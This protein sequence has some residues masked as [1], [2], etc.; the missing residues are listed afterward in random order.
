MSL[1]RI[2]WCSFIVGSSRLY[3]VFKGGYKMLPLSA[4][5][6]AQA[7]SQELVLVFFYSPTC[8]IS[9]NMHSVVHA[10]EDRLKDK[11]LFCK[12]DTQTFPSLAAQCDV[13]RTP[14]YLI[15]KEGRI[16]ASLWG[17]QSLDDLLKVLLAVK[18]NAR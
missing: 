12:V 18:R 15:Y 7:I 13:R 11:V 2:T 14:E 17:T 10:L 6:Y 8:R 16:C 4:D 9:N 5:T 3:Y 1:S